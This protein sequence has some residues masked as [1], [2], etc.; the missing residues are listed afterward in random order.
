MGIIVPYAGLL[1]N[2]HADR[3]LAA[4][5]SIGGA[6]LD[7]PLQHLVLARK[8]HHAVTFMVEELKRRFA[9]AGRA[10]AGLLVGILLCGACPCLGN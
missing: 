2:W 8:I 4:D 7:Q 10:G 6:L 9:E 5:G 3:L 1:P